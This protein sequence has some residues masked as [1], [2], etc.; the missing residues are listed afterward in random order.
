[1]KECRTTMFIKEIYISQF[2]TRVQQIKEEK[3]KEKSRESNR[4]RTSDGDFYHSS[5][6]GHGHPQFWRKCSGQGSSHA[7]TLSS[8]RIGFIT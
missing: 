4:T 8:T 3:L 5:L 7:P 6:D 2:M 1:V